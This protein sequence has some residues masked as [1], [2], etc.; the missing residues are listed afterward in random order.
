MNNS[1][2]FGSINMDYVFSIP[3]VPQMGETMKASSFQPFFGGKGA[4][5]ALAISKLGGN[6]FLIGDI[7]DDEQGKLIINHLN[8]HGVNTE[9]ISIHLGQYT[10]LASIYVMNGHNQIVISSG[11]NAHFDQKHFVEFMDHHAQ[12]GDFFIV[13][14]EKSEEAITFAVKYAK[15]KGLIVVCNPSPMNLKLLNNLQNDIDFLIVNQV[16]Y[17]M[18]T[19]S[20]Y[21][22]KNETS[23]EKIIITLGEK[24]S[25]AF[26]KDKFYQQEAIKVHVVDTTGAGDTFLGGFFAEYGK[27]NDVSSALRFASVASAIKVTRMGAQEGIPNLDEVMAYHGL[28]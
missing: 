24:G 26:F 11:A 25:Q 22:G 8:D 27:T 17:E 7:G 9:G 14:F 2:V 20:K 18:M 5:Q 10:G 16:E 6:S 23:Y 19:L 12:K 13:Q 21:Q 15:Q 4:N 1:F 3:H 28:K